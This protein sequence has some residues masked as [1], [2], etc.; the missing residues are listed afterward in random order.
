MFYYITDPVE[1]PGWHRSFS[2]VNKLDQQVI[3]IGLVDVN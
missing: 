3:Y 2:F 1:V